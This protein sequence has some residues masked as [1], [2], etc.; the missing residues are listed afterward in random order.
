MCNTCRFRCEIC[1]QQRRRRLVSPPPPCV[2]L[3]PYFLLRDRRIPSDDLPVFLRVSDYT[4]R[5]GGVNLHTDEH[6]TGKLWHQRRKMW[7]H[8]DN[9]D[10]MLNK[11]NPR[12]HEDYESTDVQISIAHYF[13]V[14][15]PRP[16]CDTW[17]VDGQLL[18]NETEILTNYHFPQQ[19]HLAGSL[20]LFVQLY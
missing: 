1:R 8:Y 10:G 2:L 9:D 20:C 4:Y 14:N 17:L 13:L 15:W 18:Y 19:I 16:I 5:L 3:S 6:C 11:F 7:V 12:D